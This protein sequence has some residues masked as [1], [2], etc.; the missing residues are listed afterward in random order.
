[1]VEAVWRGVLPKFSELELLYHTIVNIAA[2]WQYI[3]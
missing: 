3:K 2:G 1:M